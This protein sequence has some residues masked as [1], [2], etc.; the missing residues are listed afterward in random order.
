MESEETKPIYKLVDWSSDDIEGAESA[1]LTILKEFVK[2]KCFK[3]HCVLRAHQKIYEYV[4]AYAKRFTGKK[5]KSKDERIAILYAILIQFAD[6]KTLMVSSLTES[7]MSKM[8][9]VSIRTVRRY[10]TDYDNGL[11]M[12]LPAKN[13][14]SYAKSKEKKNDT[15]ISH[16]QTEENHDGTLP[17]EKTEN[18]TDTLLPNDYRLLIGNVFSDLKNFPKISSR[19]LWKEI[20]IEYIGLKKKKYFNNINIKYSV[21]S[22]YNHTLIGG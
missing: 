1:K 4:L 10:L 19:D 2:L 20:R 3:D 15:A 16:E 11:Y 18:V 14:E 12:I 21:I 8:I 9:G 6:P 13:Q 22:T 7:D 5:S 17:N